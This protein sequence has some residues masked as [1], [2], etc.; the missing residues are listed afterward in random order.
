MQTLGWG[1][2]AE[3]FVEVLTA[4]DVDGQVGALAEVLAQEAVSVFVRAALRGAG[5]IAEDRGVGRTV[6]SRWRPIWLLWSPA[7]ECFR[8]DRAAAADLPT[9]RGGRRPGSAAIARMG[10][11]S[12]SDQRYGPGRPRAGIATTPK[13]TQR[14]VAPRLRGVVADQ[15]AGPVMHGIGMEPVRP[16]PGGRPGAGLGVTWCECWGSG[17]GSRPPRRWPGP[18]PTGARGRRRAS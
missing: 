8:I 11:F 13:A 2:P 5:G 10:A 3:R 14:E 9:D 4:V 1:F 6:N 7:R 18:G 17:G 16:R 12:R 15:D